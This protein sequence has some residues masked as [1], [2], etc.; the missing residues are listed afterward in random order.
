MPNFTDTPGYW[1]VLATILPL[2][3]FVVLLLASGVSAMARRYDYEKVEKFLGSEDAGEAAA[4][5]ALGA[6]GLA[7]LCS[8]IGFVQ[9]WGERTHFERAIADAEHRI[10]EIKGLPEELKHTKER[11]AKEEDEKK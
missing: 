7:F 1:F 4:N 3:S 2:A 5:I 10:A 6:I 9:Y 8:F 11:L